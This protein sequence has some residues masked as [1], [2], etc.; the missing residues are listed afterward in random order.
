MPDL[1]IEALR[2]HLASQA[3][4]KLAGGGDWNAEGY[5]FTTRRG[6]PIKPSNLSSSWSDFVKRKGQELAIRFHDLRHSYETDLIFEQREPLK[7]VSE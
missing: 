2:R 4:L 6:T 7:L 1:L 5:L 3:G